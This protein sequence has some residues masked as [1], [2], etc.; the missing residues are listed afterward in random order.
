MNRKIVG[1][2][3][4][5]LLIGTLVSQVSACTGFT[6]SEGEKVLV[7]T[8]FD[9]SQRFDMYRHYFPAEEGK[10]GRVIIDFKFPMDMEPYPNDPDWIV[11]KEGMNDQ[12]LFYS[13]FLA[14][15]MVPE[16]SN[17]KPI[18]YS[19]DPDYYDHA[20]YAYCLAKCT[21]VS[22][23]LDV[24]DD[25]NLVGMADFQCFVADRNGDSVIIEGDDIFYKEKVT[26][27]LLRI[28]IYHKILIHHIHVRDI[29][30]L[31]VCLK[32]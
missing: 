22:E 27:K 12:G 11:P 16:N 4:V 8:N 30:Q 19:D 21:T 9:W 28:S 32:T 5:T 6:A 10:Y 20:F 31:L 18:F 23:V 26:F 29:I 13:V 1:I 3:V 15:H 25:Y 24:F 14:P 7:G 2:L 17:D